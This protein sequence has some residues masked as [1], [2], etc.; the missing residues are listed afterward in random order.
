[1]APLLRISNLGKIYPDGTVAINDVSLDVSA[2]EFVVILGP[3]GSGKT[4][5]LRCINGLIKPTSG[6]IVLDDILVNS[7][8]LRSV[9]K[10]VGLIFQHFNLVG[11]LSSLNNVLTGLLGDNSTI[12]SLCFLFKK[13]LKIRALECLDRVGLLDKARVRADKLSGG[14]QQRVGIARAIARNPMLILADEPVASLDPMIAYS[15]LSLLK[16]IC[17]SQG[18]TVI[19]NI[20]QV[21]FALKFADRIIGLSTGQIVLD[22]PIQDVTEQLIHSIYGGHEHGMFFGPAASKSPEDN[23]M[24]MAI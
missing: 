1:M 15:V 22:A 13:D 11:N 18:I 2:G 8:N 10:R 4:S 12:A 17:L 19:C 24:K 16:N 21:D 3:S 23:N 20:H 7:R 5:L 6:T 9:R 14:Q